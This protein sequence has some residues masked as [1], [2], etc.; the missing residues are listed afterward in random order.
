MFLFKRL[1]CYIILLKIY[2]KLVFVKKSFSKLKLIKS[3]GNCTF[4]EMRRIDFK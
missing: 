4:K 2:V 1:Y 3:Y